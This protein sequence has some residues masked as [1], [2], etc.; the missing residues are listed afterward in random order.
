ML[1]GS[2]LNIIR[3]TMN[4]PKPASPS[5]P[6]KPIDSLILTIRGQ[7]VLLDSDL[8]EL[9]G[10][11]TKRLNEAVKRNAERFPPDFRFQLT[12]EEAES[13]NCS[14]SQTATLKRGQNIKYLPHVF[15]E[16][17]AIM[18][19][20]VLNSPEAVS[21][22]VFVVRAFVQMREHILANTDVLKRLAE[23]DKTLLKHDRSLQIIWQE[24]QPLL[25]PPPAA[26]K[27]KIGFH[28]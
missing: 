18:A 4:K 1:D 14:R 7:K 28:T 2:E 11:P 13:A 27:R 25:T 22:S 26:P 17:G 15:T 3:T 10:V 24:I 23:I 16:H 9:Y 12:Q 19:A 8:A 5:V 6:A 21:M 20:T